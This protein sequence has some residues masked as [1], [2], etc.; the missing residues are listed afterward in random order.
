MQPDENTQDCKQMAKHSRDLG[1]DAVYRV[2]LYTV[3]YI[4]VWITY[5][6]GGIG[7]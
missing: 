6:L 2:L 5:I 3:Y 7:V 4:D 1:L